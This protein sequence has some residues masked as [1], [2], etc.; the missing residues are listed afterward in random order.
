MSYSKKLPT[1]NIG[2]RGASGTKPENTLAAFSHALTLGADGVELDVRRCGSGE[3][4]V[5]HDALLSR[6]A[7]AKGRVSQTPLGTLKSL[8]IKGG[9]YIPT[10]E[11]ALTAIGK[12][13]YCFIELKK[14][15]SAVEAALLVRRFVKQGWKAD[16]LIVIGFEHKALTLALKAYPALQTGASFTR[17]SNAGVQKAKRLGAAYVIAKYDAVKPEHLALAHKLGLKVVVWTVNQPQSIARM[18]ILGV[19]GIMTDYP[20][21]IKIKRKAPC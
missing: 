6:T 11:E 10:L 13:A 5:I 19:D 9:G 20:E 3:L 4:V 8:K 17:L 12:Q 7:A 2:H 15:D 18:C 21:R 14:P 1:L 16:R